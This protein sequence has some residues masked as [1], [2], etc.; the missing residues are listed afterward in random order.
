MTNVVPLRSHVYGAT[1][2]DWAHMRLVV[3]DADLLPVVSNPNAVISPQSTMKSLGKTP[4]L[5]NGNRQAV[6]IQK[7]TQKLATAED[8]A[9]WSK[10]RDYGICIQCRGVRG[11]DL[12][13]PDPDLSTQI[14]AAFLA[15]LGLP[16]LGVLPVRNRAGTGKQLLAFE[17]VG[18]FAKRSFK[19][20]DGAGIVEFLAD[21]Q[22][23]IAIGTH[24][25]GTRYE[26][27]GGL[28]ADFH[29]VTAAQFEAAWA[30]IVEEFGTGDAV[31]GDAGA[32]RSRADL[33]GVDD[34][35]AEYLEDKGL[36]LG[37]QGEKL[38]VDCPWKDGHSSDSGI[39]ETAW[40]V[41]GT[42][43]FERG[44][45][46]C[47][48]ASCQARKDEDFLDAV[49]Y[50]VAAFRNLDEEPEGG[51]AVTSE[52]ALRATPEDMPWPRFKRNPTTGKIEATLDNVTRALA[53]PPMMEATVRFDTFR[54]ELQIDDRVFSDADAV[55]LRITLEQRGFKPVGK[56]MMRDAL[57]IHARDN[58]FDS[59]QDWLSSVPA[60]D[61]V[62]RVESCMPR[63]FATPD[64]PYTRAVGLYLW[65]A[66]AGR[67]MDPGCK[68]DMALVL[69]GDQGIRKSSAVAAL[70]P[71]T[72]M[73]REISL[74][75]L[76]ADLSRRL[77]GCVVGEMAELRGLRS[78]DS[79]AIK[80]W[81]AQQDERWVPKFVERETTFLRRCILI[82]TSNPA[83]I[84][85]D[86]TGERRWLPVECKG[87]LDVE[88]LV[89]ERE[90]LWA[91]GLWRWRMDGIAWRDAEVLARPEHAKFKVQD[92]LASR[93]SRWVEGAADV[94]GETYHDR[95]WLLMADLLDGVS[96]AGA[97]RLTDRRAGKILRS[98]GWKSQ[99][100]RV[101]CKVYW[102]WVRDK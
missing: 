30:A 53:S 80:A 90:Q 6:G 3:G 55:Q 25:S 23:F 13:C 44:H 76:D 1:P 69:Q 63:L 75:T 60:W 48:H 17:L 24:P 74:H 27:E 40:L 84:L 61:G 19:L 91:E 28:P 8:I 18:Q 67:I 22:Q 87:R 56:E 65:T 77:R 45:F 12:D 35:V 70:V 7:W 59:A 10:E 72:D 14:A 93:V 82:G 66:L 64:T 85:D 39:S 34:P 42:K 33:D 21:G 38:F 26:W 46:Q 81:I 11:L 4:S 86:E 47:L 5:Y 9:R 2:A 15:A 32:D 50:R 31:E 37:A 78:R 101:D 98:M 83:A 58:Q 43:G 99:T 57:A 16:G 29:V 102:A 62:P 88:T 92:P 20:R 89:E 94:S 73:F 97:E 51:S 36:I 49:G 41:A 100:H 95:G 79:E 96:G 68:A 71:R 54:D 52:G